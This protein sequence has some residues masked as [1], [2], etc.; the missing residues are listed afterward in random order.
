M[1][2][3]EDDTAVVDSKLRVRGVDGLRVVDASVMPLVSNLS[4]F[5]S[6]ICSRHLQQV[7]AHPSAALYG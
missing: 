5:K 1:G 2:K 6:R 7:A 4:S 3:E